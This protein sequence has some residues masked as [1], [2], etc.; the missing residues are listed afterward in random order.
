[1]PEDIF[2]RLGNKLKN[3]RKSRGITQE[4]LSALSG[5]STRHISKI[6]KGVMNP[7]YEI[8]T[9][10][11]T[12]LGMT[13]DYFFASDNDED[14]NNIQLLISLYRGCPKHYRK[15]LLST[16]HTLSKEI[17]DADSRNCLLYTSP[18]PR[19]S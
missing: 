14:E 12:A 5:V 15:L 4:E 10:I 13:L 1:M 2:V 18:S 9:Q 11:A 7:S 19:D 16:M 3:A 8:L 17:S 6:E